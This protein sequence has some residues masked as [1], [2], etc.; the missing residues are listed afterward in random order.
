V[1]VPAAE[2]GQIFDGGLNTGLTMTLADSTRAIVM[3]S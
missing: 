3:T 2:R 1:V